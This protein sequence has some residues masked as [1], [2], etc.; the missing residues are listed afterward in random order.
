MTTTTSRRLS[1]AV[2]GAALRRLRVEAPEGFVDAV[3]DRLGLHTP[4]RL[5]TVESPAGDL[6]VAFN[7][8]GIRAVMP[9]ALFDHD[10]RESSPRT[11]APRR[12]ARWS[13]PP[14]LRPAS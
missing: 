5:V 11:T 4:D 12:A 2:D 7:D 10:A 9:A 1:P 6:F 8:D 3:L 13:V 14:A